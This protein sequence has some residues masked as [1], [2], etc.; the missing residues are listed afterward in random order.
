MTLESTSLQEIRTRSTSF[1]ASGTSWKVSVN[2]SERG[3][4]NAIR[5]VFCYIG[6]G[7]APSPRAAA[8]SCQVDSLQ[9]VVYGGATG[10]KLA[11]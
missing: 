9:M 11:G 6:S 2:G 1:Q 5:N 7:I 10:G 4:L 8:G 3:L